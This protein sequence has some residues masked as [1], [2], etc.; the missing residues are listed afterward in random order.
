MERKTERVIEKEIKKKERQR[1]EWKDGEI[2]IEKE[3]NGEKN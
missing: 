1:E 3:R 2:V